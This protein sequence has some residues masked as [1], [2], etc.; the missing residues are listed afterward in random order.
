MKKCGGFTLIEILIV[1]VI[2]SIVSGVAVLTITSNQSKS[3][4]YFANRLTHLI[5]L[6][7]EE[8]MLRPA[9]L[10]LA[11]TPVSFEFYE[12]KKK[13]LPLSDKIFG[14]QSIPGSIK[15]SLSVEN[16]N[17]PLD[18]RPHIVISP[19][20]DLSSFVIFVGKKNK[21]PMFKIIG[22]ANGSVKIKETDENDA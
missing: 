1:M 14:R 11:L 20:G 17:A 4:E 21:P 9:T 22:E 10:G 15:I 6:S 13:W 16:N 5:Q 18:G 19:S 2:I 7:E 12:Y 8:A 3:V